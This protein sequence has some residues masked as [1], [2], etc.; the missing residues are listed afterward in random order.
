M[1]ESVAYNRQD[2]CF[3]IA[4]ILALVVSSLAGSTAIAGTLERMVMPGSVIAGH[5]KY[6]DECSRCH[7]LFSK[8]SQKGLCLECHKKVSGDLKK[9]IGFHGKKTGLRDTECR[10]C[11]T[12]HKGRQADVVRMD[13]DLFDHAATDFPLKGGHAKTRCAK[14]HKPKAK[15]RDAPATCIKC[16]KDDDTHRERLGSKCAECHSERSWKK[17]RFDHDKTKFKLKGEH[18]KVSCNRCHPND[19]YKKTPKD[20]FTCHRLNDVHRGS[21][22][23]KCADCHNPRD[24]KRTSFD[25]D[26]TKFKL[27]GA[28]TKVDCTG[29]H[30][31]KDIYGKKKK[32]PKTCF[33]C[34]KNDD[35]HIGRYG[36]K[37]KE[38][39]NPKEWKRTSFDHDKTKFKLKGEHKK[40]DCVRCH[41]GRLYEKKQRL[42]KLPKTCFGCHKRDDVHKGQEGKRCEE[43]HGNEGWTER[44]SFEHDITRFPLIGLHA[45]APCEACHLSSAYKD[46][47]SECASCH[48]SE[49][50]HKRGLGPECGVC[51]NPN[52]WRLWRYDH[53]KQTDFVLDGAHE[54]LDCRSCHS[55]P[56]RRKVS[57]ST[58]CISCH[59]E[60]DIHR[61]G[62]GFH[63]QR[64]H[65][66]ESF[67]E[68]KMAE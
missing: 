2:A 5:A 11:H 45:V 32:L 37:C 10:H 54:G 9:K 20:C 53:D 62:F 41:K 12:D 56:A 61:G 6:E 8:A 46:A 48:R 50:V 29:C 23:K 60:D 66:N 27:K 15:Y 3:I 65:T 24:W 47:K 21:Y 19:R 7:R 18:K 57:A 43:C 28:H 52:G 64:C 42:R 17:P 44:V 4:F 51:H 40:V 59:R 26:K 36:N 49:D 22:G 1:E 38:C 33:K 30:K 34:H 35:E 14:C 67:E 55:R 31:N 16:H 25:H 13:S 39:H 63:C 68:I 58:A